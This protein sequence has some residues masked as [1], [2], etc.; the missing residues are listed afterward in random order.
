MTT[1]LVDYWAKRL[2]TVFGKTGSIGEAGEKIAVLKLKDQ[3]FEVKYFPI[4]EEMQ[5]SGIDLVIYIDGEPY[6]IDVKTNLHTGGDI[7]VEWKKLFKSSSTYWYHI[8]LKNPD[9]FFAYK[10]DDMKDYISTKINKPFMFWFSR[11]EIITIVS[12]QFKD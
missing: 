2:V 3:G 7:G 4:H 6:G 9:D 1:R 8:N 12:L 10:V 5:N 11:K